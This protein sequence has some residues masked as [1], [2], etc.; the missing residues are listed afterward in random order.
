MICLVCSARSRGQLCGSCRQNLAHG[1]DRRLACGVLVR[2]GYRHVGPA[3][4]LVHRLKYQAI[5][6]AAL[7][8]AEAMALRLADST[9]PLVPVRRVRARAWRYGID[10]AVELARALSAWTAVPVWDVLR[11][12]F[13]TPAHAGA[14]RGLRSTLRFRARA[15]VERPVVMIDDVLTTGATLEA[16]RRAVGHLAMFGVTATTAGRVVV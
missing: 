4:A 6:E 11:P 2:S 8:L 12:P 16:A 3:R 5:R 14:P 10:P 15:V 7:P 9:H 1:N 13:R